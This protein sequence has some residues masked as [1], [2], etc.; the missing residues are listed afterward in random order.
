MLS[1]LAW[2]RPYDLHGTPSD[3]LSGDTAFVP[4]VTMPALRA[5][6]T[7]TAPGSI[8]YLAETGKQGFFQED[9]S[10]HITPDD[11]VMTVVTL[12]GDRFKRVTTGGTVNAAWFGAIPDDGKDDQAAIQRALDFC[13]AHSSR[14][15]TVHLD[16][17]IFTL[18]GPL[19]LY[20]W[21]GASYAFQSTNLEG[22]SSFWP[23]SGSGTMLQCKFKDKFAV[24]VQLGKG[25]RITHI[26]ITGLFHPPYKDARHFYNM[27]FEE[28]RD[29][30]CRD[31]DFSPYSGIVIDPFSNSVNQLPKD[32]GYP[33]YRAWY[34]GTGQRSGSTGIQIEDVSI[35]GFVIG[36]CSSPNSFTRNAE[37]TYINKIQFSNTKLCISGSEDQEKGNVVTNLGCWGVTHTIFA[38]GLYGARTPGNWTIENANIAGSVNR[39]IYNPQAGYFGSHFKNIFAESLGRLGTIYS[40]QGTVFESSELGFAYYTS[41]DHQ[42]LYPQLD[43]SGVTFIGCDLRMYGTF[44]PVT[45]SGS[46]NFI[47]CAFETVPFANYASGGPCPTFTRCTV[48]DWKTALGVSGTQEIYQPNVCQSFAYGTYSVSSGIARLTVDNAQPAMAYPLHSSGAVTAIRA[49]E[50]SGGFREAKVAIARGEAGRIKKGDVICTGPEDYK[51]GIIGTVS[52]LA[53]G[54]VTIDYVPTWVQDGEPFHLSIFLPMVNMAFLG[55]MREGSNVITNVTV[56]MGDLDTFIQLG[57]LMRCS[58]FIDQKSDPP[59]QASM[60]RILSYN[61]A[62]RTVTLDRPAARTMQGVFFSNSDAVKDIHSEHLGSGFSYLDKNGASAILEAG[63]HI[64]VRDPAS[65]LTLAYR[66]IQSGYYNAAH[67]NDPRQARWQRESVLDTIYKRNDSVLYRK[68]GVE[69]LAFTDGYS[70]ET[71]H[72]AGRH[73]AHIAVVAGAGAGQG[74]QVEVKGT[75]WAGMLTVTPGVSGVSNGLICTIDLATAETCLVVTPNSAAAADCRVYVTRDEAGRFSLHLSGTGLIPHRVYQWTYL[76]RR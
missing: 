13:T 27:S 28:F 55:D 30:T 64:Y 24:G 20:R 6:T 22:E 54:E 36:V 14:Y 67:Y 32:G 66:V 52:N 65:G 48:G 10:D 73:T 57:G 61:A 41:D 1:V 51:Q 68:D 16:A 45:I 29:S 3:H 5:L 9:P 74:A 60:F 50:N 46:P 25:N 18:D 21:T 44:K 53:A 11:S 39:L 4:T 26:K 37:L 75:E 70:C 72:L 47:G 69:Y 23:A 34:R 19:L 62:A 63:G 59:Y 40:N 76:A 71:G 17:G 49:T 8:Y 31:S 12:A 56:D 2:V 58:Q 7:R 42:Y 33:G 38:T 43:C 35:D 15:G